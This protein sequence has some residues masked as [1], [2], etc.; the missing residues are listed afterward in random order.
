[1]TPSWFRRYLLP[2]VVFQSAVI[3]GGY[4]TGREI[5][6]FFLSL[7][8]RSGLAAM[9]V[10]TVIWSAVAAAT[11]EFARKFRT[12]EY[13]G[14]FRRLLGPGWGLFEVTYVLMTLL[15]LA[16][17]GAAAGAI[18]EETFGGSYALGVLAAIGAVAALLFF[19]SSAIERVLAGWSFV[20]YAVYIVLVAWSL[21]RW[22]GEISTAFSASALEGSWL[23]SGIRYAGY[24]LSAGA[25]VLFTVRHIQTRREAVSAGL[26]T[27][28]IG[29]L[30]AL[31]LYLA[32]V[33]HYPEITERAVPAN[34]LLEALGSRSFQI[35]FQVVLFGTLIETG[36][37]MIHAVNERI[38]ATR[39]ERG[40]ETPA[41]VRSV[42]AVVF[43]SVA[44]ALT[45]LGL[46]DLIASGYGTITWG[47]IL[48]YVVPVLTI[49]VWMLRRAP[50]DAADAS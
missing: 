43:L 6:E 28:V 18:V 35:A 42:V 10:S 5:V 27:G 14:F 7:G 3:A 13:R 38:V 41:W 15:V 22:G 50:R 31:F 48:F 32:M 9:A 1:M 23:L 4:G 33:A 49:G 26:L 46:I 21:S 2:G 40:H 47:F 17:V 39:A 44:L 11:F 20:L 30:P 37:G 12:F 24:N 29:I 8:P 25:V 19:G 45:P 16:V 34:F 36:S